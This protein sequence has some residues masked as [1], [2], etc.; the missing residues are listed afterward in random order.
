M[1]QTHRVPNFYPRLM[2]FAIICGAV[3]F[4]MHFVLPGNF[5]N[6]MPGVALSPIAQIGLF[7]IL[8]LGGGMLGFW[9]T[10]GDILREEK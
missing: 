9:I 1:K 10:F 6:I 3:L 5:E 7:V 4:V 2:M 8:S